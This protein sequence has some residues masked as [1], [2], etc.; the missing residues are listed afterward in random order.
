MNPADYHLLGFSWENVNVYHFDKCLPMGVCSSCQIFEIVNV[1]LQ[2]VMQSK[3][4]AGAMSH[5]LDDFFFIDLAKSDSQNCKMILQIFS[6]FAKP[7]GSLSKCQKL[8]PLPHQSLYMA[9][10][11]TSAKWKHVFLLK[12]LIRLKSTF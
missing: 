9:L 10:K 5:I 4:K 1:A 12:K 6:T 3:H 7:L 8:K 2:C 11:L